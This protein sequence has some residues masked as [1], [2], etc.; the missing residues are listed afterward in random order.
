MNITDDELNG[1]LENT[2]QYFFPI[3]QDSADQL[4]GAL[5]T[6]APYTLT[7]TQLC[8]TKA[9]MIK[10]GVDPSYFSDSNTGSDCTVTLNE[11]YKVM[12]VSVMEPVLALSN[13]SSD[14]KLSYI[15]DMLGYY[16]PATCNLKSSNSS[17]SDIVD[18]QKKVYSVFFK[19]YLTSYVKE[20]RSKTLPD[21]PEFQA[22]YDALASSLAN[23]ICMFTDMFKTG[24]SASCFTYAKW[25]ATNIQLD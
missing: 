21:T 19:G 10:S 14:I 18:A 8:T 17:D 16:L 3:S 7:Q 1:L 22:T 13:I 11:I 12:I 24:V 6:L 4:E 25:W 2:V 15:N 20:T 5:Q 9:Y 23:T